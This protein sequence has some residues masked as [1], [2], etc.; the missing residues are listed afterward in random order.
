MAFAVEVITLA[1]TLWPVMLGRD[2]GLVGRAFIEPEG[3]PRASLQVTNL[4]DFGKGVHHAVDDSPF[5]GGAGMVLGVGPLHQAIAAARTRQPAGSPVILMSPGGQR[6]D[7]ETAR[8]L[9]QGPGM[10]LICGRYEGV[11]ERVWRYVDF[12]LCVGDFVLSAGDPAAWA[13]VDAVVRLL[14]GVLGNP[15]SLASESFG[16]TPDS[17]GALLEYPQYT[18]PAVYDG[19]SVPD[20]LLSGDHQAVARWRAEQARAITLAR[21]PDLLMPQKAQN[22]GSGHQV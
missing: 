11:D 15:E 8:T 6:F 3:A 13:V 14:P 10:V 1:P 2:A 7:Q 18:R 19:V 12:G 9:A 17:G 20:V 5:G 22:P 4:R 21:R 16:I